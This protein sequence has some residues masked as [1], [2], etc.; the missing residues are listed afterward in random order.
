VAPGPLAPGGPCFLRWLR[1]CFF[2]WGRLGGS[3]GLGGFGESE[4]ALVSIGVAGSGSPLRVLLAASRSCFAL[5]A[6]VPGA[7]LFLIT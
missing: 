6:G 4:I 2:G 5:A 1:V 7:G 3:G